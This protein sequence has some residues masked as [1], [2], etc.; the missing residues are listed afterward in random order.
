MSDPRYPRMA[1]A[2]RALLCLLALALVQGVQAQGRG[3]LEREVKAA[4]LYRFIDYVRWP[5]SAFQKPDSPIVIGVVAD[6]AM[7][8]DLQ[9]VIA[10]RSVRGHPIIVRS[11]R[12]GELSGLHVLFIG[13]QANNR[14]QRI[15]RAVDG[16]VLVVTEA[17]EGLS[18][19]S[20]INFVIADRRVRFEVA[21][22][23][24]AAR[25]LTIGSGL[26]SVAINVRKDSLLNEGRFPYALAR[27]K[28]GSAKAQ[29]R[30]HRLPR[31]ELF[32]GSD[33]R[34]PTA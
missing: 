22:G 6:P 21:L 23:P 15:I 28:S 20:I 16:P 13:E 33:P 2:L 19:G 14:L 4:F 9:S 5:E 26:L 17:D 3:G 8:P 1:M 31:H 27:F 12:E 25:S 7:V 32:Q 30:R 24:A 34:A 11:V 10:G 29:S 18:H